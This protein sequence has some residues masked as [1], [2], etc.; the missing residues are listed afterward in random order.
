MD[1]LSILIGGKAGFGIDKSGSLIGRLL[2]QSG[3]RVYIYRDYPSLIRGGHT[4]SIIRASRSR[5][6]AHQ[7][8]VDLI[9]A[10]NQETLSLHRNRLKEG[11]FFI[12]DSEQL[13]PADEQECGLGLPL[14][15]IIK[16]EH[17]SEIMRNT[18]MVGALAKALGLD[19][20]LLA[21]I[22]KKEF[23][24]EADL[25]LKVARRG[26][27]EARE[28]I[29]VEPLKQAALPLISGNQAIAL[30]LIKSGL[31]TYISYPMTPTSPIL[32][33]LAEIADS[34]SL[35]VIHPESE[36]AVALMALGFSYMGKKTAVGTSG[37]GFCLMTEGLSFSGIAELPIVIILGQRPGPSTGLP[38]YS[39]QTEL[40]FALNAGQGE[41]ARFIV[42]PGDAEEAYYWSAMS[43]NISWKYQ[44]PGIILS[45]KNMGEGVFNF[46]LNAAGEI[47]KEQPVSWDGKNAYK[48]YMITENG[49]S[50]L[51]FPPVK[52]AV[53]KVNSYE[54]DENGITTEEI[55]DTNQMQEK[56]L[57]KEIFLAEELENIKTVNVFGDKDS[58]TALLC[59]GSNK[60]VCN[61][62]GQRLGLK[63]VQPI[64]LNPFPLRQFKD[65]LAGVKKIIC[66]ESNAT[67]QL[68]L[69]IKG[70]GF[71]VDDKILK[72]DGR[73]FSTD[74]L[75]EKVKA[76]LP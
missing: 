74:E 68:V 34:F 7:E 37:G 36:I 41:F 20:D 30:G 65:A 8:K 66:V 4:F 55:K 18:C 50:P 51:S 61:E 38:T 11:C 6:F 28:L 54:H 16:E 71:N 62:I 33:F 53:I 22:L 58:E 9:L 73:P 48:R 46:D 45:D 27:N 14:G 29:K 1:D 44:I 52:G 13:K 59:W 63:V 39:S 17:A 24:R 75:E 57:R 64:V 49:V 43:M 31:N 2:N 15:K 47:E 76:Y 5:I 60:G 23:S 3:Y 56:R 42:S 40:H 35:N 25:N 70:H 19:F 69:L 10:L 67:G 26:F 12:F 21:G 72:Y 32:H